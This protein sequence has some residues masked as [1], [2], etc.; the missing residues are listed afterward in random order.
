MSALEK[1]LKE[2]KA[3]INRKLPETWYPFTLPSLNRMMDIE[4]QN[5]GLR[6][7]RMHQF[8]GA[9]SVGKTTLSLD[10]LA[11]AQ[12]TGEQV[13]FIDFERTYDP[14]YASIL[15]IDTD[16]MILVQTDTAEQGLD[17]AED[18]VQAGVKAIVVDSIPAA[19]PKSEL[20]KD[21][22]DS[23]TMA[24]SAGFL[25]RWSRRMI[26]IL[27][28]TG[29][30]CICINQFR[31]NFSKM[32]P[33]ETKPYGPL[34]FLH[35]IST[36]LEMRRIQNDDDESVVQCFVEKNK[37]GGKEREKVNIHMSYGQGIDYPYDVLTMALESDIIRKSG[38]WFYYGE[39]KAQGMDNAKELFPIE[40]IR[41]KL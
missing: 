22:E 38:A 19:V 29:S 23:A 10:I 34:A 28:N 13:A 37:Q 24:V 27:S 11:N 41:S 16:K 39:L 12:R 1:L 9:K 14:Y 7:G 33:K 35:N 5:R 2:Q 18:L 4:G 26:P 31:A 6:G 25:T 8:I 30:I 15:G 17:L 40:E 3:F 36:S 20:E 21:M 32:S